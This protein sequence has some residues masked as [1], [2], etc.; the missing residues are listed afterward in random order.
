MYASFAVI[1]QTQCAKYLVKMERYCVYECKSWTE[2]MNYKHVIPE[3]TESIGSCQ[4]GIPW[5]NKPK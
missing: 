3:N 5:N 1:A 2:T 4:Q